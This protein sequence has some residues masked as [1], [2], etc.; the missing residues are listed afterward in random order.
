[1][2][3]NY[4]VIIMITASCLFAGCAKRDTADV[5]AGEAGSVVEQMLAGAVRESRLDLAALARARA[6]TEAPPK[7]P[8]PDAAM[9]RK[10]TMSWV[11]PADTALKELA[12]L[13]DYRVEENGR[14]RIRF[15]S[16]VVSVVDKAAYSVLEDL[17]LQ[18]RPQFILSLDT[19]RRVI[20]L[21][22]AGGSGADPIPDAPKKTPR[23]T[24]GR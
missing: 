5:G 10:I 13:T 21:S 12:R 11:G 2:M 23:K 17:A 6:G 15:P 19:A 22:G 8:A 4:I 20:T 16:V 9:C 14:R 7:L 18:V 1:M 24:R 3:K